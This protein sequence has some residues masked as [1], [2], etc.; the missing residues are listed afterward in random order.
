MVE[1]KEALKKWDAA[2]GRKKMIRR[3]PER[4]GKRGDQEDKEENVGECD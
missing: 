3:L 2:T 1:G 4:V